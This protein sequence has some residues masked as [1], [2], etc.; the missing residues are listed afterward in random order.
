[1]PFKP[2]ID[3]KKKPFFFY[4]VNNSFRKT[5]KKVRAI[6]PGDAPFSYI[7]VSTL[8]AKFLRLTRVNTPNLVNTPFR[9][10][11]FLFDR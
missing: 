5:K 8:M 9:I 7:C 10:Y 6:K 1:M 2:Y 11:K 3:N 4:S